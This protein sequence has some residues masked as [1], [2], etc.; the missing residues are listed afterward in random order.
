MLETGSASRTH[1]DAPKPP[2]KPR[3]SKHRG[4]RL[5]EPDASH[6]SYRVRFRDPDTGR[7]TT[8]T[9]PENDTKNAD[10]RTAYCVRLHADLRRRKEDISAG[11]SRHTAAALDI[12]EA[13]ASY[14]REFTHKDNT[15]ERYQHSTDI[16]LRWAE[17]VGIRRVRDLTPQQLARLPAFLAKLPRKRAAHGRGRGAKYTSTD[18]ISRHTANGHLKVVKTVL[19]H[20]RRL[21]IV[22]LSRDEIRDSL[23]KLKAPT[24]LRPFLRPAQLQQVLSSID[25]EPLREFVMFLLLTGCR[26]EEACQLRGDFVQTDTKEILIPAEIAKGGY[27]RALDVTHSVWLLSRLE[28]WKTRDQLFRYTQ[29]SFRGAIA[30]V[31]QRGASKFSGHT[32]RRTCGTYLANGKWGVWYATRLLG[33]RS[34]TTSEKHYIGAIRVDQ[35]AATLEQAMGI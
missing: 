15:R 26:I 34:V 17:T 23:T 28:E 31:I 18:V 19:E 33:H 2:R 25:S 35:T 11:A 4:V 20:L 8:R 24:E 21:G 12:R 5:L 32:L 6:T 9:I 30:K 27:A 29:P 1:A 14:F 22:R 13:V 3:R 16:L 10:I 7:L